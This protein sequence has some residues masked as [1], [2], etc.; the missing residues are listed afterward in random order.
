MAGPRLR[1]L[2]FVAISLA[3]HAALV[4]GATRPRAAPPLAWSLAVA[5]ARPAT[6]VVRVARFEAERAALVASARADRERGRLALGEFLLRA[7]ALDAEEHGAPFDVETARKLYHARVDAIREALSREPLRLAVPEVMGDLRYFGRPGGLM[8]EALL[9]GGGSCEQISHLVAAAVHDAGAAERVAL[10]YYGG[11]MEGGAVHLAAVAVEGAGEHDL[12]LGRRAFRTGARFAAADL[13]EAYARVHGLAPLLPSTPTRPTPARPTHR[14][15]R[16]DRDLAAEPDRPSLAAGYPPNDDRFPGTVPLY[17]ARAVADPSEDGEE[18]EA[19]ALEQRSRAHDCAFEVHIAA[20]DPPALEI[21]PGPSGAA[22]D[23]E[24]RKIPAPS[25]LERKAALLRGA[26]DNA[27]GDGDRASRLMA[28]ACIAGLARDLATDFALAGEI[29]LAQLALQKSKHAAARGAAMLAAVSWDGP[30]GAELERRLSW[31]FA[32]QA[33]LLLFL[34]GG[35]RAVLHLARGAGTSGA[36]D[37]GRVDVLAALVVAPATRAR[38]YGI[39]DGLPRR[40]QIDVMHEIFGAHQHLRPWASRYALEEDGAAEGR[41]FRRV[42]RVF[43]S[44]AARLWEE[45]S[46]VDQTLAALSREA[47]AA[48]LDPEWGTLLLEYYGTGLLKVYRDRPAAPGAM[49]LLSRAVEE[50][51][52]PA[53]DA[54]RRM[55][56]DEPGGRPAERPVL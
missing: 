49:R 11:A 32:G 42:Y 55:L 17:A 47:R 28:D 3:S 56:G 12:L 27:A 6:R 53:L 33:W 43:R 7:N 50:N 31:S 30:E 29:R 13:V 51:R 48:R 4:S 39:L 9:D 41:E 19:A 52:H 25:D 36:S 45:Q 20:L 26:E 8:A 10:R 21:D 23:V 34:D 22:F 15:S 2:V 24:L 14:S 16:S 18:A 35:E 44:V 1:R 46:P 37:Q 38:A 54:L 40:T 5:A